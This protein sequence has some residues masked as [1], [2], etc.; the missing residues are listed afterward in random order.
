MFI[1]EAVCRAC[2]RGDRDSGDSTGGGSNGS[3]GEN[4]EDE[5][6]ENEANEGSDHAAP[7]LD[8]H[9]VYTLLMSY[10]ADIT[11]DYTLCL[12]RVITVME[13]QQ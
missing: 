3:A 5:E 11:M 13:E 1:Y 6:V 2:L 7:L 4:G 9:E 12:C 8:S 10:P